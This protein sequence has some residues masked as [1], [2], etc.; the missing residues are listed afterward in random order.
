M[1]ITEVLETDPERFDP[2]AY[3]NALGLQADYIEKINALSTEL[4]A[5]SK[6]IKKI[7]SYG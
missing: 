1:T 5:L 2:N 7:E 6:H 3:L 4:H